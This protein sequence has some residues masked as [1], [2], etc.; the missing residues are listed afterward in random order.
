[1]EHS[2][3]PVLLYIRHSS[4][5]RLNKRDAINSSLLGESL[6]THGDLWVLERGFRF[7]TNC[8]STVRIEPVSGLTATGGKGLAYATDTNSRGQSESCLT[9]SMC[10][11]DSYCSAGVAKNEGKEKISEGEKRE[12]KAQS[13][14][15]E[16]HSK[17]QC[18]CA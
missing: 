7:E 6:R 17:W 15:W 8:G 1:M 16:A 9:K 4:M 18:R 2:T 5:H 14:C 12:K 3:Y 11:H 13:C 10:V